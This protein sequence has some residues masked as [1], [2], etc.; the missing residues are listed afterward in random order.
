MGVLSLVIGC[1]GQVCDQVKVPKWSPEQYFGRM[2]R[3]GGQ[4]PRLLVDEEAADVRR[5]VRSDLA[6]GWQ[7]SVAG[8]ILKTGPWRGYLWYAV[9]EEEFAEVW[10]R[11][12]ISLRMAATPKTMDAL[13]RIAEAGVLRQARV[14]AALAMV[15][16]DKELA[17]RILTQEYATFEVTDIPATLAPLPLGTGWALGQLGNPVAPEVTNVAELNKLLEWSLR[18]P[19][20]QRNPGLLAR[21]AN[22]YNKRLRELF[23]RGDTEQLQL[24]A[25]LPER[26][27]LAL[28]CYRRA[29]K[30][31]QEPASQPHKNW[32][33]FGP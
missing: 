28:E 9:A 24:L 18:W 30:E 22:L 5:T 27:H 29:E 3:V 14:A 6:D 31:A 20:V 4:D 15:R 23:D 32:D 16:D 25:L 7:D 17:T 1:S 2:A 10:R 21:A 26:S 19:H 33:L 8:F 12:D 13:R 11:R